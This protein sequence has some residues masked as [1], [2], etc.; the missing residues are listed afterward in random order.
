MARIMAIDYGDKRIG[1]SLT[2]PLNIIVSPYKTLK[3]DDK[4]FLN[5]LKICKEKEVKEIVI[6]IPSNNKNNIGFAAKKVIKFMN[7]FIEFCN[8]E[9]LNL[10]FYEQDESFSTK[11]AYNTMNEIRVK[12]K[13]KKNIVDTIASANILRDFI[14]SKKKVLYD[15]NKYNK[16][17]KG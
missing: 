17:I 10:S 13:N 9:N 2:D 1:I 7:T 8:K 12:R 11:D 6:G 16:I 15:F 4:I 3:N 5:L 14:N